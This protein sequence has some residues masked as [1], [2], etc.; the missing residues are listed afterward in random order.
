MRINSFPQN[1]LI[2]FRRVGL[3]FGILCAIAFVSYAIGQ[4]TTSTK[5]IVETEE[6]TT[7]KSRMSLTATQLADG[8][9]ELNALL[10]VKADESYQAVPDARVVFMHMT[11][12][13]D[14][15]SLGEMTTAIN[16]KAL[17][18]T[19][20]SELSADAEGYFS[21]IAR[22]DGNDKIRES[23]SDL[24]IHPAK[25]VAEAVEEDS[26]YLIRLQATADSPDGPVPIV[27]ATVSVYVKRMFNS[28]KVGEG[29]TDE[30][31]NVEIEFP[32]NLPGDEKANLM[33]TAMIEESDEYGNLAVSISKPW[34]YAVKRGEKELPRALWS[35]HPP[36]WMVVT[37]FILMVTVWGNYMIIVYKLFR[38]RFKKIDTQQSS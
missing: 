14:E 10:R 19:K 12:E 25:L 5:E 7:F 26:T 15:K 17:L 28:L 38:I 35:P 22:Y 37:F 31:G 34:G 32:N 33:I 3:T 11:P 4:D 18:N 29:A 27:E 1:K 23:E 6:A 9:I 21:F 30:A 24:R 36:A 13:G 2:R 20:T 16:G 8:S